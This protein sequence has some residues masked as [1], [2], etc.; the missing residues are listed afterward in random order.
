MFCW[1]DLLKATTIWSVGARD[2]S[3]SDFCRGIFWKKSYRTY[4]FKDQSQNL[5]LNK[6]NV[7]FVLTSQLLLI[8]LV[9]VW[10]VFLLIQCGDIFYCDGNTIISSF[11]T[12][13]YSSIII[14][15]LFEDSGWRKC[16]T[17]CV[18]Y[19]QCRYK[20]VFVRILLEFHCQKFFCKEKKYRTY[21]DFCT[22]YDFNGIWKKNFVRTAQFQERRKKNISYVLG[23]SKVRSEHQK[24]CV[25]IFILIVRSY[26]YFEQEIPST[27]RSNCCGLT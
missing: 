20:K 11:K 24:F 27:N 16:H 18:H 3:Y 15:C 7:S 13:V 4:W 5:F 21:Y 19:I 22:Y 26:Y 2:R 1:S 17:D 12:F 6:K 23:F 8:F 9:K 25:R 14:V 10:Y